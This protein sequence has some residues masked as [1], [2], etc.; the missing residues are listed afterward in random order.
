LTFISPARSQLCVA[1]NS[2][3]HCNAILQSYA[4]PEVFKSSSYYAMTGKRKTASVRAKGAPLWFAG[5]A[6]VA[7][8]VLVP[9]GG[10][11]S[12]V[13]TYDQL[14]RLS[15]A[16]YDNGT[17]VAYLYDAGGNR[18]SQS[19]TLSGGPQTPTWGTGTWGCFSWTP[20]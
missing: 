17:C 14:G 12:A 10:N 15:T 2:T 8:S 11:A 16:L 6:T 9:E 5:L 18:T 3:G 13:F 7:V 4:A 19:I 1:I 20:Q